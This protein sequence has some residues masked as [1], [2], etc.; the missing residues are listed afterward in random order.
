MTRITRAPIS[1]HGASAIFVRLRNARTVFGGEGGR[2]NLRMQFF[3][4]HNTFRLA[5]TQPR[6]TH[7]HTKK[8]AHAKLVMRYSHDLRFGT[9]NTPTCSSNFVCGSQQTTINATKK[10]INNV[11]PALERHSLQSVRPSKLLE[12]GHHHH[13]QSLKAR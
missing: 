9:A 13:H 3:E 10:K 7:T 12:D 8:N 11:L 4:T 1:K 5:C 2:A 6:R